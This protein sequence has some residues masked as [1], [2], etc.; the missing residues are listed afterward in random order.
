SFGGSRFPLFVTWKTRDGDGDSLRGCIGNFSE[1]DLDSGLK[2]Y[3]LVAAFKD[4]RFHPIQAHELQSLS[5][6]VSLLVQFEEVE[7]YLD[8][9]VGVHGIWIEF[10][11]PELGGKK[12]ATY[13]PEV[14]KEQGWTHIEA[15][16]SLLRKGGY[17]KAV[18]EEFRCSVKVTR[19]QSLKHTITY[20]DYL[21][22]R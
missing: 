10:H 21:T 16:N 1:L 5:C 14:A 2:E 12:T 20:E 3:A 13:L 22:W 8:W 15:L 9:E 4:R 17:K 7:H 18:T 19:Y 11:A 6:G